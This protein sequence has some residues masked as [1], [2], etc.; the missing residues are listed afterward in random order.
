MQISEYA[1]VINCIP[2]GENDAI[3]TVFSENHGAL[4]GFVKRVKSSKK[5]AIF[6][7]GNALKINYLQR[8][9]AMGSITGESYKMYIY[10]CMD[11]QAK[12]KLIL[13][14]CSCLNITFG[15]N[16]K[17]E[18]GELFKFLMLYLEGIKHDLPLN[19]NI[20]NLSILIKKIL[21]FCGYAFRLNKCVVTGAENIDDLV[22]LSPKSAASVCKN[23]GIEYENLM[24]KLPKAFITNNYNDINN[25]DD[26]KNCIK[27]VDF[28]VSK[29][30]NKQIDELKWLI[31][32]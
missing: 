5:Q 12:M 14:I 4:K 3:V 8:E 18:S 29:N 7:V 19:E 30:F 31:S 17:G 28:F 6:V 25:Y 32:V 16:E 15:S 9:G 11:T 23:S 10:S 27:I 26:V 20:F 13:A 21:D 24:L 2:Y 1:V 22:F